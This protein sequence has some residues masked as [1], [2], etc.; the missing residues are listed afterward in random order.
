MELKEEVLRYRQAGEALGIFSYYHLFKLLGNIVDAEE[1]I[2]EHR[3]S[4]LLARALLRNLDFQVEVTGADHAF[5][6]Q[7]YCLVC[8][9]A[10]HLDWAVLLGYFP[11]PLRFV[12]KRELISVP[13]VGSYL[14]LRGILIDRS[15]GDTA[16]KAIQRAARDD[17]PFPILLFPEGTRSPDGEIKTFKPGGL[18]IMAEEGLTMVPVRITGTFDAFPRHARRVA[19]GGTLRL[20]VGEPVEPHDEPEWAIQEI[21]RRVRRLGEEGS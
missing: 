11:S 10:S 8:T 19:P 6:L 21:E 1:G 20:L 9:H 3:V 13:V 17:S 16:R 18:R 15:K 14:R 7:H 5:G 12:A 2:I 4:Q